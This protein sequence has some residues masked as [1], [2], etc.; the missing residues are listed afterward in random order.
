MRIT[1]EKEKALNIISG[2]NAIKKEIRKLFNFDD[3]NTYKDL[4]ELIIIMENEY[5]KPIKLT[6]QN[7]TRKANIIKE[8]RSVKKIRNAINVL[9]FENKKININRVAK[10]AGVSYNTAKKYKYLIFQ[11]D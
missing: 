2:F 11:I 1:I 9:H 3:E 6:K 8:E 5:K 4:E 7:A 10:E